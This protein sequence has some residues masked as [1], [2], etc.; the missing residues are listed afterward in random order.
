[1]GQKPFVGRATPGHDAGVNKTPR[2][3]G[4]VCECPSPAGQGA[5]SPTMERG[6]KTGKGEEERE[7]MEKDE[8][9]G[10]EQG[11]K[12]AFFISSFQALAVPRALYGTPDRNGHY[13]QKSVSAAQWVQF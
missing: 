11:S 6:K 2:L 7:K 8:G 12:P 4:F 5:D 9:Q 10:N 13:P 1:M 3:P